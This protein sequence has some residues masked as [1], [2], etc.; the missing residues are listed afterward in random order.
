MR[1]PFDTSTAIPK[2]SKIATPPQQYI[3]SGLELS[4]GLPKGLIAVRLKPFLTAAT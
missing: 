3:T 1:L 4:F 2:N